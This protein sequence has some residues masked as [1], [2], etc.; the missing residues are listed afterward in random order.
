MP[1]PERAFG[2]RTAT[3]AQEGLQLGE[4]LGPRPAR[5]LGGDGCGWPAARTGHPG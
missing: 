3:S 5:R 1:L 2:P 4:E